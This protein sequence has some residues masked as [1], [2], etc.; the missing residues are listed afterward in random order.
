MEAFG[1]GVV[2][3]SGEVCVCVRVLVGEGCGGGVVVCGG[4]EVV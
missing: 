4:V 3:C 2:V 1:G